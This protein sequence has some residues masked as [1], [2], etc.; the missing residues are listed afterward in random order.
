MAYIILGLYTFFLTLI[1][2]YN[3]LQLSLL[4]HYLGRKRPPRPAPCI[5]ETAPFVTVQ[6]PLFNEMTVAGRLIDNIVGMDYPRDRFEVQILDDSTDETT[7]LCEEKARHYRAL[8]FDIKVLHRRDRTGYKAGALAAGLPEAKGEFVA[9]F[10]SDFLPDS[11]FLERT[12]PYLQNDRVGVVQT[13][14][15][16]LNADYSLFTKLQALQLNVHFTIE[17]A[18]RK[19]GGHFL[20][21]NGTAGVWRKKAIED[22]GGWRADTLTEDLDL[23]YRAQ[24]K[25]WEIVYLEEAESPAELPVAMNGIK[26]QQFRWM[27]GGA[28]NARLLSGIILKSSLPLTTKLHAL[29]H[30]ANSSVFVVVLLLALTSVGMVPVLA[31]SRMDMSYLGYSLFGL[32]GV[33]AVFFHAN[34]HLEPRPLRISRILALCGYFPL[35]LTMS[36]GLSFHNSV[37]VIEGYLGIKSSFVRT[38]KYN[39]V[40]RDQKSAAGRPPKNPIGKGVIVEGLLTLLFAGAI[41]LGIHLHQYGFFVFH[42]MLAIGFGTMFFASWGDR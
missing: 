38:P 32:V 7:K 34:I 36:M 8:G 27:K 25:N 15:G 4:F 39:I 28:E 10:D 23:S 31:G 11:D 26:S 33:A 17:Q 42:L 12:I 24:L 22:A 21:F 29:A 18:G 40:G 14:W 20:Q 3:L 13:R 1:M 6:L 41:L 19:A 2:L 35:L 37:A 5:G 9:I 30:L 16:H